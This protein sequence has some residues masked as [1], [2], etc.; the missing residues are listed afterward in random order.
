M[1]SHSI[2][3]NAIFSLLFF[4]PVKGM[5]QTYTIWSG[6]DT[7]II[8]ANFADFT[9][10][11]HQDRIT[12]NVWLTRGANDGMFNIAKE[13]S[14]GSNSPSGTK[15][16]LGTTKQ[17]GLGE[18][19]FTTLKTAANNK[20][21]EV[22]GKSFVLFLEEEDIYIDVTFISW[23]DGQS[24][25]GGFSYK[26]STN[27]VGTQIEVLEQPDGF[28]LKQNYP[29]PFNPTTQIEFLLPITTEI[30]LS[31]FNIMGKKVL[32]LISGRMEAGLHAITL[33]ASNLPSGNYFYRLET[34][35]FSE[36]KSMIL[37]K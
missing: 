5:A 15:W 37:L 19:E 26:R 27:Q 36:V 35:E 10:A 21:K 25:G 33:D 16:A 7:T 4:L 24:K 11:Q 34:A 13:S 30:Q 17:L 18:L 6:P 12:P 2:F 29:N 8:K 32:D 3:F 22:P 23:T 1:K 20:M 31:V 9:Q 28:I 14:E